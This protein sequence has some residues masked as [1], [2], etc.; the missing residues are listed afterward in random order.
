MLKSGQ[1]TTQNE[2]NKYKSQGLKV[3][4]R[5]IMNMDIRAWSNNTFWVFGLEMGKPPTIS[6]ISKFV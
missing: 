3:T 2:I 4:G 6:K 1:V 5:M